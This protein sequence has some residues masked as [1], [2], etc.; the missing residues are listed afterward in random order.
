[1]MKGNKPAIMS[2][3]LGGG[4][5]DPGMK[6]AVDKAVAAGIPVVVAAGNSGRSSQ[7]D[8]CKY[9]PAHI[10]SAITVGATDKPSGSRD[11]RAAYSSY[12]KCLDIYAPGSQI[13]SA[14]HRTKTGT[15]T[16]SGTSMACP[17]VAGVTALMMA[18]DS[19]LTPAQIVGTLTA[20]GTKGI[21]DDPK[22]G[23]PN[24]MLYAGTNAPTPAPPPTPAP[25]PVPPT[26]A[27]TPVPRPPSPAAD[28]GFENNDPKLFY[29]PGGKTFAWTKKSGGTP[30]SSTGPAKAV[31]G[32]FYMY[33]E[34][35]HPRQAGDKFVLT[36]YPLILAG[37]DTMTFSYHMY[38]GQIGELVVD[39]AGKTVWS[40]KGSQGNKWYTASVK[41]DGSGV[42]QPVVTF[43]GVRGSS[44]QGDIAIDDVKFS[45]GG[46]SK[47]PT[48]APARPTP[49]PA[50]P[51]GP[52]APPVVL[53][54]PPGPPGNVGT[55]GPPGKV[56]PPGNRG[57]PGPPR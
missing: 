56:G 11:R 16:M 53:P 1:M 19:S 8:A 10:P 9:T 36:S 47:P 55:Q 26:P 46:P 13:K 54:G 44:W 52:P 27:P 50:G 25:T 6:A 49:A 38:G 17:H 40:K 57:P 33:T 12:G 18:E 3:S 2:M 41:I 21:I 29:H 37:K 35:S 23:S 43:T 51:P 45:S 28:C 39:V 42:S 5:N 48:P 4:G 31:E 20:Q 15:A 22:T 14:G 34:T 30:S 32:S 7:P 24:I